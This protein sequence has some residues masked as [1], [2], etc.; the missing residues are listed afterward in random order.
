[1]SI[2]SPA[3]SQ[4]MEEFGVSSTVAILPLSLYVFALALGPIVGGPL[5]ETVGRYPV[6]IGA[7]SLGTLF[8]LGVGFCPTFAGICV[9]RFLAGFCYAPTLAIAAGT[10]NET[11]KPVHRALPSAIFILTPFWGPGIGLLLLESMLLSSSLAD[12]FLGLSL[13]VS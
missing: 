11:F 8:T 6:Y 9:L 2:L 1:M 13:E 4:F 3:H 12:Y 5:S 10:L 7:I